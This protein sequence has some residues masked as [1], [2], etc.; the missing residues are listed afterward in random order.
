MRISRHETSAICGNELLR[1]RPQKLVKK[2]NKT[3]SIFGNTLFYAIVSLRSCPMYKPLQED[4]KNFQF[5]L[6][7]AGLIAVAAIIYFAVK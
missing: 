4:A 3:L 2:S 7:I 6:I 5:I 1:N